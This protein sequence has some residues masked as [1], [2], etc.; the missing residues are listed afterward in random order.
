MKTLL[1]SI[2]AVLVIISISYAWDNPYNKR[3]YEDSWGNNYKNYNN[4]YKDTDKDGVPN[5]LD[6]NDRN[7][8]IQNPYQTNRGYNNPYSTGRQKRYRW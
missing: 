2:T 3:P 8:N 6:Y 7:R 4:L 1:L 5:Y